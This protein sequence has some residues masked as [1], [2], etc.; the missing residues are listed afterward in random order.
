MEWL[1]AYQ[2]ELLF[3]VLLN[4]LMTFG[5]GFYKVMNLSFDQ[6]VILMERYPVRPN[7]LKVL[8]LWFLPYAGTLYI[9]RELWYLQGYIRA[10]QGVYGYLEAKLKAD[11]A[12]EGER[13]GY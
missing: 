10:G 2:M 7:Y 11:Y 1:V 5:F 8:S 12:K 3:G 6:T 9:F 4:L 13:D